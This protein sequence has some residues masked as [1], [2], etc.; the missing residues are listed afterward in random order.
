[1]FQQ[2]AKVGAIAAAGM[3][4]FA[5]TVEAEGRIFWAWISDSTT[6]RWTCVAMLRLRVGP[7]HSAHC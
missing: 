4:G 5:S 6:R 1:M 2:F 3:V 7:T